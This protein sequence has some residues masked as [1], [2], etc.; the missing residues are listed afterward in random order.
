MVV[1]MGSSATTEHRVPDPGL[2]GQDKMWEGAVLL[3]RVGPGADLPTLSKANRQH[4]PLRSAAQLCSE[5][6][7]PPDCQARVSPSSGKDLGSLESWSAHRPSCLIRFIFLML[8]LGS[9]CGVYTAALCGSSSNRGV[10]LAVP[11][12]ATF[13]SYYNPS[14]LLDDRALC[15]SK[16]VG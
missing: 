14:L 5:A 10:C 6:S 13:P 3:G 16:P 1:V 9:V 15:I 2:P 4:Y 12:A 11:G 8:G 7:A